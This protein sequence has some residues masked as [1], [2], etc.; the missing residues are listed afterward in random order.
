MCPA[1]ALLSTSQTNNISRV[2]T[3]SKMM[4]DI[5]ESN[6]TYKAVHLMQSVDD[7]VCALAAALVGEDYCER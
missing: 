1:S 4:K 3:L 6:C 7:K 5:N 2:R